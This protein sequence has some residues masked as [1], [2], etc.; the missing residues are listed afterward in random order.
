[1]PKAGR[2]KELRLVREGRGERIKAAVPCAPLDEVEQALPSKDRV[3]AGALDRLI[4]AKLAEG[5]IEPITAQQ[6]DVVA[7]LVYVQDFDS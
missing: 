7:L 4:L 6:A 3:P 1:M 2:A 5:W